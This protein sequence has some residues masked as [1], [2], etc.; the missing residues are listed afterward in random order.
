MSKELKELEA[1]VATLERQLIELTKASNQNEVKER[2]G[3]NLAA[4]TTPATTK[5]KRVTLSDGTTIDVAFH[6]QWIDKNRL[7]NP[8]APGKFI[9][10]DETFDNA[11]IMA[12]WATTKSPAY[13]TQTLVNI[14]TTEPEKP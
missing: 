7:P 13:T 4:T 3:K 9:S 11:E 14:T 1:R 10:V 5:A 8:L 12:Y 2:T 6:Q